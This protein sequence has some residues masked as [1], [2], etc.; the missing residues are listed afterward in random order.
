MGRPQEHDADTAAALIDAAERLVHAEGLEALTVRRVATE[1]GTTTRAV[2][3][4]FGS[5][6]GLVVALGQR[7]FEILSDGLARLP[8]TDDPAGDLIEAGV[9]IFRRFA[10]DHPAL[11][12]IAFQRPPSREIVAGFRPAGNEALL[13]LKARVERLK[14]AGQLG[15]RPVW[16][17]VSE[18]DALCE[19]LAAVELRGQMLPGSPPSFSGRP[20]PQ[21][22]DDAGD[23]AR[24]DINERIWRGALTALVRG[25]AISDAA[26]RGNPESEP[27]GATDA[28]PPNAPAR[29]ARTR[30]SR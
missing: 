23:P 12:R 27:N 3:T 1:V 29:S 10:L 4:L 15:A 7:A 25:F 19:G 5:K 28:T 18:F 14:A 9:H 30:S 17:S 13:I 22:G 26:Y 6:E 8:E 21:P 16:P 24:A 11:F 20:D 2:Y